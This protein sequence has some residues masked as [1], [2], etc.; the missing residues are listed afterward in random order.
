MKKNNCLWLQYRTYVLTRIYAKVHF[1]HSDVNVTF[2]W[3]EI[4]R[5]SFIYPYCLIFF[6]LI[7]KR[8]KLN[9][10]S[11]YTLRKFCH[12]SLIILVVRC[13]YHR[14]SLNSPCVTNAIDEYQN[15]YTYCLSI[16]PI[17]RIQN[18]SDFLRRLSYYHNSAIICTNVHG[19]NILLVY[20]DCNVKIF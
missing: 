11:C 14:I 6:L 13:K 15:G 19:L 1:F 7:T 5:C 4:F 2:V 12:W 16:C 20:A 3:R 17:G 9:H 10:V 8:T 18:A